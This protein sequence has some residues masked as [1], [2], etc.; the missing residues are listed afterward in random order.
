[1]DDDASNLGALRDLF[2]SPR[3][4]GYVATRDGDALDRL[5]AAQ[6]AGWPDPVA[7]AGDVAGTIADN[8]SPA[9]STWL[10]AILDE[11]ADRRRPGANAAP[12]Q[13]G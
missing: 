1:M 3:P 9:V 2:I 12:D 5:V 6:A 8:S 11:L 10:E 7:A 4:A 13:T